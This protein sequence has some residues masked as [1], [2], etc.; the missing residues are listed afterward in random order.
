MRK[1]AKVFLGGTCNG[2]QWR[3]YAE[4]NLI[5]PY[6]NPVVEEWDDTAMEREEHEKNTSLYHLYVLT[7]LM[8]GCFSV[9]E[10]INDCNTPGVFTYFSYLEEDKGVAFSRHQLKAMKAIADMVQKIGGYYYPS[11]HETVQALNRAYQEK[12]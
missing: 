8:E 3:R 4:E 5:M 11:L 2:S 10:L 6:F 9:A 12:H 7:P 1:E